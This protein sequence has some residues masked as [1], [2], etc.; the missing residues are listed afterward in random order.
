MSL[1]FEQKVKLLD[2]LDTWHT[3]PFE[4]LESMLMT[5]GPHGIRK[6]IDTSDNIG[7]GGSVKATCY[8]TASLT[9]CS[10]DR[11]IMK[12]LGEN[13]AKEAIHHGVQMV[14]G[15]GINIKRTP[16]CGRNFEYMSEDPL[17][18]GELAAAYIKGSESMNVGTSLKHFICNNQE[19]YRFSIDSI[20]DER[21]LHEIYYKG[22]KRALEEKPASLMISYN[23]LNG[24]YVSEH[25]IIKDMIRDKW[26]YQGVLV[27]DWGAINDRSKSIKMTCDL[28]MPSSHGY[29]TKKVLEDSLKDG[30]LK[31]E[32]LNS[33]LRIENMI[34]KYK[35]QETIDLDY[36]KQ[37][38]QARM[39]ARESM[40]L[41]KNEDILP[42][43]E[44]ENIVFISGFYDQMRYQGGGSSHVNAT[45][46]ANIIDI[47]SNYSKNLKCAKGFSIDHQKIDIKLEKEALELANQSKKVIYAIGVPEVLETEG[48]DRKTLD[49]PIN[50]VELFKKL[51]QVNQNIIIVVMSGSVVNLKPFE[52]AKGCLIA[53]LG[54]QAS[55]LAFMDI[56]YG[57]ISPSGRLAETWIDDEKM[58]NV[59]I[60]DDNNAIFYDESIF[61]GYRYY[62]TFRKPVRYH[63]GHGLSYTTFIYKDFLV[64]E[65][66]NL[67]KISVSIRNT[68]KM[69]GKEVVLIFVENNES[70]VYKAKRELKAF[71][72]IELKPNE[73]K[74]ISFT[75]SK[76]DFSFYDIYQ[77]RFVTETGDYQIQLCKHSGLILD[78]AEIHIEGKDIKHPLVSYNQYEYN[79]I[80][81]S[82]IYQKDLPVKNVKRTRPYTLSTTIR[83]AEHTLMGK[84]IKI[85]ISNIA[86]KKTKKIQDHWMKEVIKRSL[87][88]SPIRML[89]LF[90]NETLS[91][92]QAEGIV[93]ILNLKLIKG[94]KKLNN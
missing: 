90:S 78:Q 12:K 73:I 44:K 83:E 87:M 49:L 23:K 14:L 22:F 37:H 61:V 84:I 47:A 65:T 21:A 32:V 75:L 20:V 31:Q 10:F 3:K 63:F 80:D 76:D 53:Y 43:N 82:K 71:D 42:L 24:Q 2:G 16:L 67:Y 27:S 45:E 68:G 94:I 91:L 92:F 58:C 19:K 72:K 60:T 62:E 1:T 9:A 36:K 79:P 33:S 40:V 69:V 17:L 8:P 6:Q 64:E 70:S 89:A 50:Q 35:K 54:G 25:P 13:L 15:P 55:A 28:E 46:V 81:F 77:K 88:E 5:D 59:S 30:V 18:S 7:V 51:Y 38:E 52:K 4:G 85:A 74:T 29:W 11:I 41:T 26:G 39:I 93:D 48:F 34:K 66:D 56:L 86:A 57:K